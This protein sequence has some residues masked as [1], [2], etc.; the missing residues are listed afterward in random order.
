M[1]ANKAEKAFRNTVMKELS[2]KK[3]IKDRN[4]E[5]QEMIDYK[6]SLLEDKLLAA[7]E[8]RKKMRSELATA[9]DTVVVDCTVMN[10]LKAERLA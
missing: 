10:Q 2:L 1:Y 3:R 8:S 9:N 4:K 7:S 6:A 5:R